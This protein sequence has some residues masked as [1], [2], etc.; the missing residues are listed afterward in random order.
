MN[1]RYYRLALFA[2]AS[3]QFIAGGQAFA[4]ST[5]GTVSDEQPIIVTAR[6]IEERLQ[7]VPISIS[8]VDQDRLTKSNIASSE[9]LAKVVPGLSVDS[10]Y[11]SEQSSFA[12]RGFSQQLRTSAAVGTYFGEVVA[13]RGSGLSLQGGDGA[14]PG[15]LFD[16]QNVQVLKGPQGTLFGRNTTGGAVI[17]TPRKPTDRFEGY[18]EG[19]YGN[20]EMFRVQGVLNA[21]LASWARVRLGVDRQTR[22]GYV[23][24]VSGIGPKR[25]YDTDYVAVRGSLVLDLSPELENY[26]IVSYMHS[27]TNGSVPQL[28]RANPSA[29]FGFFAVPQVN[30][31]NASDERWQIEQKLINPRAMTKQFQVINTTTW[32]AT[33]NLTVK[34]ITSYS[35]FIQDLRQDIFGTNFLIPALKS[36]IS[37]AFSFNP[38]GYHTSDQ[39]NFTEELQFQGRAERL[40]YQFGLYFEHSTPGGLTASESP[41]I[42]AVCLISGFTTLANSRCMSGP[43]SPNKG[44][45]EFINMAAYGQATYE[46]TD[47]LKLTGGIRYTY[48][49]SKGMAQGFDYSYRPATPFTFVAP[50]PNATPTNP[51]ACSTGY[52]I[53]TNC[54]FTGRTSDKKPTWTLT[55]QYSPIGD[56]MTYAT[57]SRGYKQGGVTPFALAG[58]PFYRP[59]KLDNFEVGA[60]LSFRGTVSGNLN[61][62]GFYSK[63]T[64]QQILLG[65][66]DNQGLLPS[67]TSVINAGKSRMYGVDFDG[68]LRFGSLFR[69]DAA[70]TYLNTKIQALDLPD[71][72]TYPFS[73]YEV[74]QAPAVGGPLELAPKWSANVGGTFT[75]PTSED[76]G[77]IELAAFYRYTSAYLTGGPTGRSTPIKQ[78]DLNLDWRNIGGQ[79]VDLALFATNVTNQFTRTYVQGLFNSFG[80]DTGYLGQPRMYGAR[81]RVRFGEGE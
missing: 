36:Y 52:P 13:P 48:D 49:R 10:R 21:P 81:I 26:T 53:A 39:K 32:I 43:A 79:P 22:D 37:T 46:L 4:Q 8:V 25:F 65:L 11:S 28:F 2:T 1:R 34:N 16:L 60:K 20:Y 63:L 59:E 56:M 27:D 5:E 12:I 9:D 29:G 17:L 72:T 68:Q 18:L 76:L 38:D 41:S 35:T 61:F 71:F 54:V 19:S 75:V 45:I 40:N 51:E 50:T 3:L 44:S 33:D 23:H 62:A 73:E 58:V 24:N 77:K 42:G 55:L 6:R 70:A 47:Q 69:V 64:D 30:R 67:G 74:R 78:L 7:D 80:F 15:S 31:L 14:G 57:Y 66:T